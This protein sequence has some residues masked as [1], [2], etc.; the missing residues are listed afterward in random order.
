MIKNEGLDVL[1]YRTFFKLCRLESNSFSL[2]KKDW[3]TFI[4]IHYIQY[5]VISLMIFGINSPQF[6]KQMIDAID[7]YQKNIGR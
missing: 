4:L 7:F 1:Q 2:E 5:R 6:I 3:I